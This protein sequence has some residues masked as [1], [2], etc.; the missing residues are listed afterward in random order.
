MWGVGSGASG[1]GQGVK[2]K[3]MGGGGQAGVRSGVVVGERG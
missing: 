2:I 3:K 1:G